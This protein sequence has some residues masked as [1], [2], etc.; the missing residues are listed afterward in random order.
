[1]TEEEKS[2]LYQQ[3]SYLKEQDQLK[4]QKIESLERIIDETHKVMAKMTTTLEAMA[5]KLAS[6]DYAVAVVNRAKAKEL[7]DKIQM[8]RRIFNEKR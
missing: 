6:T 8:A 3:L 5:D 4:D 2:F 7:E 1:M